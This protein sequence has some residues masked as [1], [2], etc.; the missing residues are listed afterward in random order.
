MRHFKMQGLLLVLLPLVLFGLAGC[1]R[2][3]RPQFEGHSFTRSTL[4]RFY[5]AAA[6]YGRPVSN[7]YS[8]SGATPC[9]A[10]YAAFAPSQTANVRVTP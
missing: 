4:P 1:I 5:P 10:G 6:L 8:C 9:M 2:V 7:V 3:M